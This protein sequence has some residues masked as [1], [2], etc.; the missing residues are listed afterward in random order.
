MRV[1][2]HAE[3]ND[4]GLAIEVANALIKNYME[5]S[6]NSEQIIFNR[7][8]LAEIAEHIQVYLKHSSLYL[9]EITK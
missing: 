2:F 9:E 8:L 3:E 6:A 4:G 5:T 7:H 1:E